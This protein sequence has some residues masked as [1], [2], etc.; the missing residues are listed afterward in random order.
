MTVETELENQFSG[1][2][3][4]ETTT[5]IAILLMCLCLVCPST[6]CTKSLVKQALRPRIARP[7]GDGR[8]FASSPF[9]R[10][11]SRGLFFL[12]GALL[13]WPLQVAIYFCKRQI[14]NDH[15]PHYL[16]TNQIQCNCPYDTAT[17][18][19]HTAITCVHLPESGLRCASCN[20]RG[21]LLSTASSS[22][23][24]EQKRKYLKRLTDKNVI[25]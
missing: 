7:M 20:T 5:C 4:L 19:F 1:L 23:S 21:L 10:M 9:C 15:V 22:V 6:S 12:C 13:L 8:A 16:E 24:R 25:V 3:Q 2:L 14:P 18:S 17:Y 11:A